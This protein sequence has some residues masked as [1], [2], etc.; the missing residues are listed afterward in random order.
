MQQEK[1]SMPELNRLNDIEALQAAKIPVVLVLDNIR[2]MNNVGSIFRTCD[3]F[4]VQTLFLCGVT[5]T[6]PHRDISKTALGA[7]DSVPWQYEED[8]LHL[9]Q[10]LKA[11]GYQ[12]F[13]VEQVHNSISL[14][15]AQFARDKKYAIV[16]GNELEGVDQKVIDACHVTI[17]IPQGGAK[18]SFN[19]SVSAGVVLWECFK[20]LVNGN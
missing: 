2:S 14:E 18:H 5:P 8:T 13:A 6:P 20:Q 12:V 15:N 10:E 16:M 7:T 4:A 9:I 3:G 11:Q 17:E 1:K 19:V